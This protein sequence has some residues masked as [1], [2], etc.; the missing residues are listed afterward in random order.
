MAH[1]R[2]AEAPLDAPISGVAIGRDP[3][4]DE[5]LLA[6]L[7]EFDHRWP[8]RAK[9]S[10]V[11]P[12]AGRFTDDPKFKDPIWIITE[13]QKHP[14]L[15]GPL[16]RGTTPAEVYE[17]RHGGRK[18][19]AGRD[20]K[21]GHW[22]LIALAYMLASKVEL[23][24]WYQQHSSNETL[25][26]AAGFEEIPSY[27]TFHER[28]TEL[29]RYLAGIYEAT[30]EAWQIAMARS[31]YI[32]RNWKIDGQ[33]Y[34]SHVRLEHDPDC[35]K[36]LYEMG[37]D[38]DM[39]RFIERQ[40]LEVAEEIRHKEN[41]QPVDEA[42]D[43]LTDDA[44]AVPIVEVEE[45]E[46]ELVASPA[47]SAIDAEAET[48]EEIANIELE[49]SGKK[50]KP[51]PEAGSDGRK[52]I[53]I[54]GHRYLC[55]DHDAGFK[56]YQSSSGKKLKQWTGGIAL[57]VS[58]D[59]LGITIAT[60][61][62]PADEVE[63]THWGEL[64]YAGAQIMRTLPE[65]A[66]GDR[67]HATRAV[68]K[69]NTLLEIG[70][71]IPFRKPNGSYKTRADLAVEGEFNEYGIP[72]CEHCN[73]PGTMLGKELGFRVRNGEPVMLFRCSLPGD[74]AACKK[75]QTRHCSDEW[76]LFGPLTREE[77]LYFEL[78]GAGKP[79]E[80]NNALDRRRYMLAGAD[81]DTRAKRIGISFLD[82]RAALGAFL[83][84]FRVLLRQGWLESDAKKNPWT[85]VK[86]NGEKAIASFRRRL[87]RLGLLLPRGPQAVKLGLA[88][89]GEIPDGWVPVATRLAQQK[90]AAAKER[91]K[92]KRELAKQKAAAAKAA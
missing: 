5:E 39:P 65:N 73:A 75:I 21:A 54:S 25:W 17:K 78:S 45:A 37:K 32:G 4:I 70:S 84:I 52:A 92:L 3:E 63:H 53:T 59:A 40:A 29:E 16:E 56:I 48:L 49:L 19:R 26:Q 31:P 58:D 71:V 60:I 42:T 9:E 81:P 50:T 22:V 86:R 41:E 34:E 27:S 46:P 69:L 35:P 66:M 12:G 57:K 14:Q 85:P 44:D 55:R 18:H 28:V 38:D 1:E 20:R 88:F 89:T 15:W 61:H 87:R 7:R 74:R 67:G 72:L 79:G 47:P 2:Q 82:L 23:E 13:L 36:C 30:A 43:E 8:Q 11:F 62:I 77:P 64:L 90:K 51:T 10:W 6:A 80:K 76:L 33:A 24:V 68:K 91:A 83:D